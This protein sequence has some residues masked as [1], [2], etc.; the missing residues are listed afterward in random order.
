MKCINY[1]IDVK[2]KKGLESTWSRLCFNTRR[3]RK[4]MTKTNTR[5]IISNYNPAAGRKNISRM[6][7]FCV[8][9]DIGWISLNVSVSIIQLQIKNVDLAALK[10]SS[11]EY[12]IRILVYPADLVFRA[13][14]RTMSLMC[15]K[16]KMISKEN[17]YPNQH[18][19]IK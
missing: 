11:N 19:S 8:H 1:V 17:Y 12:M 4:I 2:V 10:S 5:K 3:I 15:Y 18:I 13:F 9:S 6:Y 14:K 16:N 7:I